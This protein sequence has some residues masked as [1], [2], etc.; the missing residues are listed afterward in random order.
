[1]IASVLITFVPCSA[2]SAIILALAGKYLGGRGVFAIFALTI[3]LVALMGR[4]LARSRREFGPGQVQEIPPYALP[5]WRVM[6]TETWARTSDISPSSRRCWS[7]AAWC[8]RCS[9]TSAPMPRSIP[10]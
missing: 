5:H 9:T 7:A 4:L 10:C 3:V 1:M 6:L 8:W 2:R